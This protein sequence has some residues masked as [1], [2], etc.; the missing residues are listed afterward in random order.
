M[1]SET[2]SFDW[3]QLLPARNLAS[4]S[5]SLPVIHTGKTVLVTGAGGSIGS[6][7]VHAI[8]AQSPKLLILL[9]HSEQNLYEIETALSSSSTAPPFLAVLGDAGDRQ[10]LSSLFEENRPS[11]VY[12]AAAFKHVPLMEANPFAAIRNNALVTWNLAR[13]AAEHGVAQFLLISTDKAANPRSIM[14]ASKRLAELAILRAGSA[15]ANFRA[16]RLGNVLGSHGSVVPLFLQQIARSQKLSVTHKDVTRYFLTMDETVNL[17]F[18]VASL[19]AVDGLFLPEMGQPVKIQAIAERLLRL[20]SPG[21]LGIEFTG[22]RPGDKLSEDLL[23]P[24]ESLERTSLSGIH[25][26]SSPFISGSKIDAAFERLASQTGERNLSALLETILE[27]VP[28]YEPSA[29]LIERAPLP[30]AKSAHH[31]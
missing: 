23:S 6:A 19:P 29:A 31:D 3:N 30:V 5:G 9:D 20:A 8:A 17:I 11:I 10:L 12:H 24:S 14:G 26:I 13:L 25:R 21:N 2:A 27:I 28:E 7:L 1:S 18:R 16:I 15:G 22:L 4:V